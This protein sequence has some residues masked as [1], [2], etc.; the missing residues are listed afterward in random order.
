MISNAP[1]QISDFYIE[2]G[3]FVRLDNLQ[4]GYQVPTKSGSISNL[5]LYAGVQNLFTI[6]NFTGVDPEVRWTD[7]GDQLAPGIER[8]DTYFIPRVWTAGLTITF[9]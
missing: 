9:K 2:R 1:S 8:R 3:D 6:T 4:L 7:G 5:R